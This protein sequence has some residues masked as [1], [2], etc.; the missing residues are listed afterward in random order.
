[1]NSLPETLKGL[2]VKFLASLEVWRMRILI[3]LEVSAP[4]KA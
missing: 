4:A 2:V 1:M 3:S